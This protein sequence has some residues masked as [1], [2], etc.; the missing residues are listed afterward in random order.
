MRTKRKLQGLGW[1]GLWKFASHWINSVHRCSHLPADSTEQAWRGVNLI[2]LSIAWFVS[3]KKIDLPSLRGSYRESRIFCIDVR[4]GNMLKDILDGRARMYT[5]KRNTKTMSRNALKCKLVRNN[6]IWSL[7]FSFITARVSF[8]TKSSNLSAKAWSTRYQLWNGLK[9]IVCFWDNQ[10]CHKTFVFAEHYRDD[11]GVMVYSRLRVF[12]RRFFNRIMADFFFARWC[13]LMM[14][15][16]MFP[17]YLICYLICCK[18][19]ELSALKSLQTVIT[20]FFFTSEKFLSMT[21]IC[22]ERF[23]GVEAWP[24]KRMK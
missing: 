22:R 24:L 21:K 12:I 4:H 1:R 19:T 8:I 2:T 3:R 7:F 20:I 10:F 9:C 18:W 16:F 13:H 6:A 5:N 11:H 15:K 17:L 14:D 23:E